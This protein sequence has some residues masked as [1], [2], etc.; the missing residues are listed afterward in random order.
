[1]FWDHYGS[2]IVFYIP[3][4][5]TLGFVPT[6]FDVW[7]VRNPLLDDYTTAALTTPIDLPDRYM[8]LLLL[9]VQK[10]V[11]EQANQQPDPNL[12]ANISNLTQQIASNIS[13]ETQFMQV[14]RANKLNS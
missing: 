8:R 3:P 4:Q 5:A 10:M 6:T 1:M 11:L 9:M 14:A 12:D 7:A 2:S 13:N